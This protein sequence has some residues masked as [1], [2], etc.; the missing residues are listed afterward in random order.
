M[1]N[2]HQSNR[3][4]WNEAAGYYR[5]GL[6]EAV[7]KLGAGWKNFCAPEIATLTRLVSSPVT[8][9]HLQC[10][11][12]TD[13]LSL[14]NLGANKVIGVDISEEMISVA[15]E[16]STRL[17]MNAE[18]I[19]SDVLHAPETLNS[20][21]EVVYTGR[22]ALNW[23]M[24]ISAWAKVVARI[25]KPGGHLYLFEGHPTTYF[26]AMESATLTLDPEFE[27]YFSGK[28]YE[29]KDWPTT[30]VGKTKASV[31]EQATKFERAWPVSS[32]INALMDAGLVLRSFEEHPDA[33]WEEFPNLPEAERTKFPNTY[34]LLMQKPQ[35]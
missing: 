28:I 7:R 19:A 33:Y 14:I 20:I 32:V 24:D 26:F 8:C 13:S 22:G 5:E 29:S 21:A 17:S 23:I 31:D 35:R 15:Q 34:S 25:L 9:V 4:A 18:W 6:D 30:Y 27:G 12:G 11:G 10:A 1:A 3:Q 16:K 2:Q